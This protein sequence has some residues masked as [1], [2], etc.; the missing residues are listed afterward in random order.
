MASNYIQ[1]T[2]LIHRQACV[3]TNHVQSCAHGEKKVDGS[4][5][6]DRH[7]PRRTVGLRERLAAQLQILCERNATDLTEET[8]RAVREMLEREGL[9]PPP[10]KEA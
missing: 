6:S 3:V 1:G 4:A 7:K 2:P 8:N 9:W 10:A 5:S